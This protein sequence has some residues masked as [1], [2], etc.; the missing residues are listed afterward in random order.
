MISDLTISSAVVLP[1]KPFRIILPV[2]FQGRRIIS[3]LCG[4]CK[5][6]GTDAAMIIT[7]F[8]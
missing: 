1:D 5:L 7:V 8:K 6:S 4:T 2:P 3:K